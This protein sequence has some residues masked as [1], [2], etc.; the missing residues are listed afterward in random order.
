[1]LKLEVMMKKFGLLAITVLSLAFSNIS[2]AEQQ[3]DENEM[4]LYDSVVGSQMNKAADSLYDS[5]YLL[6]T[7]YACGFAP[8]PPIGC[9]VGACVC[10]QNGRNCQWTFICK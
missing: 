5:Q 2:I 6:K 8:F 9:V 4:R 7:N 3:G 10:D 1:M